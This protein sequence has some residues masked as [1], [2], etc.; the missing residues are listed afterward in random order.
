MSRVYQTKKEEKDPYEFNR[1]SVN[2]ICKFKL[3]TLKL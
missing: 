1:D 3:S 2:K